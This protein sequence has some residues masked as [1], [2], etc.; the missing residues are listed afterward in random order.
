M[1]I[2]VPCFDICSGDIL[3]GSR[4]TILTLKICIQLYVSLIA[5]VD[6]RAVI[7]TAVFNLSLL[8]TAE[9]SILIHIMMLEL[10]KNNNYLFHS[11]ISRWTNGSILYVL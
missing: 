7:K 10:L 4:A 1:N 5:V 3:L 6:S 2:S 9:L 8:M 11:Y